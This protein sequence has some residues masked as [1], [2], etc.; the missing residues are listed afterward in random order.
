MD[1][2][3]KLFLFFCFVFAGVFLFL[4]YLLNIF[5]IDLKGKIMSNNKIN[6]VDEQNKDM[7]KNLLDD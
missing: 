6:D 3:S 7:E 5:I 1:N 4:S 2:K